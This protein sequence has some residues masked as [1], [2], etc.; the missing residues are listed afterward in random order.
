VV[1]YRR[2]TDIARNLYQANATAAAAKATR[3]A[4]ELAR[5]S[6]QR[7]LRAYIVVVIGSAV[8]QQRRSKEDGG[9][10]KFEC[11]PLMVN[12][13]K[14]PAT[15]LLKARAAIM[16][17]PLPPGMHLPEGYDEGTGASILGSYK[18]RICLHLLMGMQRTTRWT[19]S[20]I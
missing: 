12:T 3:D 17:V 18:T 19:E 16:P 20:S 15:K 11:R 2:H 5:Q 1:L 7:E 9:D 10:L 6:S 8:F 13:G 4:V 14:T